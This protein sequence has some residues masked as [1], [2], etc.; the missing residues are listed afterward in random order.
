MVEAMPHHACFGAAQP[1]L[2]DRLKQGKRAHHI[3]LNERFWTQDGAIHVRFG[4][5]VNDG[6]DV[7]PAQQVI[8]QASITDVAVDEFVPIPSR[9]VAE[10]FTPAGVG[11]GIKVDDTNVWL[12]LKNEPHKIRT[13]ETGAAGHKYVM[14]WR[15]PSRQ[16]PQEGA[17]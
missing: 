16:T 1:E 7:M 11:E 9:Q 15:S 5:K 12:P 6:I 14:H 13:D 17:P 8:D 3:G 4:R 2:A 10:V